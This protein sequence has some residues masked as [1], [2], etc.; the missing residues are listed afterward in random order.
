MSQHAAPDM[1]IELSTRYVPDTPSYLATP[2]EF[3]RYASSTPFRFTDLAHPASDAVPST[4][5]QVPLVTRSE[6]DMLYASP[7]LDLLTAP[8]IASP[9]TAK[10]VLVQSTVSDSPNAQHETV[11]AKPVHASPEASPSKLVRSTTRGATLRVH[12]VMQVLNSFVV[13][14]NCVLV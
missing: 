12:F 11:S 1:G 7:L 14:G 5:Q 6:D 8:M 3:R 4:E 2:A 9:P 13:N 10:P